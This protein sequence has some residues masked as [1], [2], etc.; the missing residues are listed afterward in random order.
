[1][2]LGTAGCIDICSRLTQPR[3]KK[4][5]GLLQQLTHLSSCRRND[6]VY[7]KDFGKVGKNGQKSSY[8]QAEEKGRIGK[9]C[10][11]KLEWEEG[12]C[13]VHRLMIH[14]M[15]FHLH[16]AGKL[17]TWSFKHSWVWVI[18]Y[19]YLVLGGWGFVPF[20]MLRNVLSHAHTNQCQW[21]HSSWYDGSLEK[22]K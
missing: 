17:R 21:L 3:K 20:T 15:I 16:Q 10:L 4:F 6:M 2:W 9:K 14:K 11:E 22:S 13:M 7:E 5:W 8:S 19:V 18:L 1:M 12:I